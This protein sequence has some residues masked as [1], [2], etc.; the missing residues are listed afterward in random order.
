[1][2]IIQDHEQFLHVKV[3]PG[4]P[5]EDIFCTFVY[6]KCYT[7]P[8]RL[9]WE[10]LTSISISTP[11]GSWGDFN[12]ILHP[13]ENQGGDMRRVGPIDD[14]NDMMIDTGLMD[15]GFEGDPFTWTNKRVWKR[16]TE[17]YTPK[18]GLIPKTL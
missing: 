10:E 3:N 13:N 16:L 2:Q 8:R 6:A 5:Q 9:L 17:F 4:A 12:V 1:M 18:N 11:H 14:F 7:N 15:A